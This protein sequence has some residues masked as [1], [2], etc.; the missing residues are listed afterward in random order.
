MTM[1]L[2]PFTLSKELSMKTMTA[3]MARNLEILRSA[4][5]VRRHRFRFFAAGRPV[6]GLHMPTVERLVSAGLVS[7]AVEIE[8]HNGCHDSIFAVMSSNPTHPS[9]CEQCDG[10]GEIESEEQSANTRPYAVQRQLE[11]ARARGDWAKWRRLARTS[12]VK[13]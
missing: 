11:R 6:R 3:A 12:E 13:P 1:H 8:L 4:G 10:T 7:H 5:T 2:K 9:Q